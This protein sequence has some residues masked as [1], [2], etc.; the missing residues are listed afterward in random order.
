MKTFTITSLMLLGISTITFAGYEA[1]SRT[2]VDF[3]NLTP[4]SQSDNA[5]VCKNRY[6]DGY[7]ATTLADEK[8]VTDKNHLIEIV[9]SDLVKKNGL[10]LLNNEYKIELQ[11][12]K[13]N[14]NIIA[15]SLGRDLPFSGVF[16]DDKCKGYVTL[17][18]QK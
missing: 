16:T 3:H 18:Q 9:K 14:T 7:M 17:T 1:G 5:S 11:N 4:I 15:T 6:G 8:K 2:R 13:Y 10:Y 12:V